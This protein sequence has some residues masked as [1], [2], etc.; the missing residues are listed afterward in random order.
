MMRLMNVC[1]D[2]YFDTEMCTSMFENKDFQCLNNE[3]RKPRNIIPND[4]VSI[5]TKG[6]KSGFVE[7]RTKFNDSVVATTC[8]GR[9][10]L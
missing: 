1:V 6:F 4:N 10:E 9:P 2:A 8:D 5:I 3:N 7:C